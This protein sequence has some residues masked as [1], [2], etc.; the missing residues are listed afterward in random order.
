[1]ETHAQSATLVYLLLLQIIRLGASA[2]IKLQ[3]LL[4][5]PSFVCSIRNQVACVKGMTHSSCHEIY[6]DFGKKDWMPKHAALRI[7]LCQEKHPHC[8]LRRAQRPSLWS[9]WG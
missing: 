9:R 3:G 4:Q 6:Y 2:S 7:S 5:G 8:I 1:M